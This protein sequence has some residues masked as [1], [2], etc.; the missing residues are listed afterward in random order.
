MQQKSPMLRLWEL[1]EQYH[2]GLIRAVL[3]ASIGVPCGILPYFAAAQIIIGLIHREQCASYYLLWCAAAL[4]GYVLRAVLYALAL[5]MSHK[6]TFSTTIYLWLIPL[7]ASKELPILL[8][9][10]LE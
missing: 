9:K 3:S 5:S 1:G 8:L 7:T 2:G 6:A 4:G 10:L